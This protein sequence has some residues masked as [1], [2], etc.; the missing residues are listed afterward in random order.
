MKTTQLQYH[1]GNWQAANAGQDSL[2]GLSPDLVLAFLSPSQQG[3]EASFQK[4]RKQFPD[5]IVTGCT[6]GG[7]IQ[8]DDYFDTQSVAT[9]ILFE[10]ST[11]RIASAQNDK[12]ETSFETGAFLANALEQKDLRGI[13]ILSEGLTVNGSQ[14]IQ[15][16][17]SKISSNIPI[18][19]GLAGDGA[20]FKKTLVGVNDV[21]QSGLVSAVG[22]YGDRLVLDHSYGGGWN[23]FGPE[24][25]I[26][27]SKDNVLYELD[28]KPALQLYKRYLGDEAKK[29]PGSALLY[30]IKIWQVGQAKTGEEVVRTILAVDEE[31]QSMTFAGNMPEGYAA[32]LMTGTYDNIIQG[33]GEAASQLGQDTA[34][35]P[36]SDRLAI[37]VSCI[38]RTL[39]LGQRVYEEVEEVQDT[40]GRDTSQIGFYSYGELCPNLS[41]GASELHNQTMTITT[42]SEK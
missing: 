39:M 37:L 42:L 19:G 22:F 20:D 8:D 26:T 11:V 29:L 2:S 31:T 5:A 15:G 14:L 33:A 4:L 1:D 7:Q 35:T 23:T 30:P 34:E 3:L 32:Q 36:N 24:R 38:G 17:K 41:S 25:I 18:S 10:H 13:F 28:G 6:T 16:L 21:L 27:R 12:P 40:L 9:A